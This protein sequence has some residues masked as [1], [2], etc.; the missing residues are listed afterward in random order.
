MWILHILYISLFQSTN[1]SQ[2]RT[3][4]SLRVHFQMLGSEGKTH[5][6]IDRLILDTIHFHII[7]NLV[8]HYEQARKSICP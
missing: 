2:C 7:N 5:I 1:V 4:R 6:A 8:M 3:I